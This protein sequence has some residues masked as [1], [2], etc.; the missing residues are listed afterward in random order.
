MCLLYDKCH[1]F[2][3]LLFVIIGG[4]LATYTLHN[5]IKSKKN[6]QS[7][8]NNWNVKHRLLLLFLCSIGGIMMLL[9]MGFLHASSIL[10]LFLLAICTMAYSYP[11][12]SF[13]K[14]NIPLKNYGIL[15]PFFL[16]SV[17][18]CVTFILPIIE[19]RIVFRYDMVLLGIFR[20]VYIIILCILFDWKDVAIDAKN[21]VQTIPV[22]YKQN[23][24]RILIGI[25]VIM[26]VM[27]LVFFAV[28][29]QEDIIYLGIIASY[30]LLILVIY[31]MHKAKSELFFVIIVD[32]MMIIYSV[33]SWFTIYF[34]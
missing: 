2:Y 31:Q 20:W 7:D 24:S 23:I 8:R 6:Y 33:L 30:L 10:F 19:M 4:T 11:M 17:W 29:L 27:A 15:K 32:G 5:Y 12:I 14:R 1:H 25:C 9:N 26:S 16:A 28:L 18:V 22:M 21:N 34:L 13:K 3:N